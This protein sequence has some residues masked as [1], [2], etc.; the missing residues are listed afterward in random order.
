MAEKLTK[1]N[2]EML[3][4]ILVEEKRRILAHLEGL[5]EESVEE[6]DLTTGDEADIAAIEIS[7]AAL[8]KIGKRETSLVKK[9]DEALA[10]IESGDY[11]SCD[12][13]G[14]PIALGRLKARPVATLCID[15]KQ[16]QEQIERKFSNRDESDED[17]T[18][19][20]GDE[21]GD[22]E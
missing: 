12:N 15:C 2:I 3:K 20:V 19:G 17:S 11:G 13:C 21:E 9:I 1:K 10:R 18:A 14:D 5:S 4:E 22:S 16:E 7:Q 8:Q 6:L